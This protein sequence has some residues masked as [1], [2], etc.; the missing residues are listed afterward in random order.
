MNGS[1]V[2]R[3]SASRGA[4]PQPSTLIVT[5]NAA[6]T[7]KIPALLYCWTSSPTGRSIRVV[8]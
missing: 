1:R 2:E 5:V 4:T 8:T 7:A 3:W 6:K